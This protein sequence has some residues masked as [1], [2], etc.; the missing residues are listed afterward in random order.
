VRRLPEVVAERAR[1]ELANRV[2]RL[3]H[4]QC[5]LPNLPISRIVG[6]STSIRLELDFR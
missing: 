6:A 5:G 1:F 3:R 2:R 4:F